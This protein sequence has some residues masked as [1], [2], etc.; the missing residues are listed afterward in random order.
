M[1][2]NLKPRFNHHDMCFVKNGPIYY[3]IIDVKA[4]YAVGGFYFRPAQ[5]NVPCIPAVSL[6][7]WQSIAFLEYH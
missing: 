5:D 3:V 1:V 2:A 7:R 4:G 6:D